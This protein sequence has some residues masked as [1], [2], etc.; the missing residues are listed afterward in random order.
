MSDMLRV[1]II[2][3][4]A[5]GGWAGEAHVPAVQGLAGMTLAAIATASPRTADEAARTYGVA[6]AYGNGLD[7]IADPEIDV[8]T[9]ATQVQHHSA[10]VLAALAAGKHVYSEWPLGRGGAESRE[11]AHAATTANVHHVIGLQLRMSPAVQAAR[12]RLASGAIGRLLSVSAFGSTAGFGPEVPDQFLYL[13]E[14]ANFANLVTI[15]GAHTLDLVRALGGDL[16]D[17]SALASRQ[18]PEIAAGVERRALARR[19]FD[20]LLVHG[21]LIGGVPFA[22]E[23]AGGRETDTP[24]FLE[25]VG[26]RGRLRLEGGAARGPQAGPLTLAENG[27]PVPIDLGELAALPDA[28]LNVGAV[29]AK[30]REDILHGTNT[31]PGFDQAVELTTLIDT[32]LRSSDEGR[33]LSAEEVSA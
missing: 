29:Y 33:R 10:L 6:K 9:V 4:N 26:E 21:R 13:E 11:M 7:L 1:G 24:F 30:F 20:H 23:V 15:Q 12:G 8:V 27:E 32:A 19:T 2:G 25:L 3:A 22:L 31:S 18:F 16:V 28:A 14:P 17:L 5:S